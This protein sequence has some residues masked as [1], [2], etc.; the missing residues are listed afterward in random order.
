MSLVFII[1]IT[2]TKY[3]QNF[4]IFMEFY[5]YIA[6]IFDELISVVL[7]PVIKKLKTERADGWMTTCVPGY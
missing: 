6:V 7:F 1:V 4:I 2:D 5:I 3:N